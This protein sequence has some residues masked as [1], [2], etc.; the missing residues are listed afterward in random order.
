MTKCD[1]CGALRDDV[2]RVK[3]PESQVCAN[4]CLHCVDTVNREREVV[5]ADRLVE[6][7]Q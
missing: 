3:Q 2:R 7:A 5:G 6:V 4:L 1:Y